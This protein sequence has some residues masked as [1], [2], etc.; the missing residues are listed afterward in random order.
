MN[1][2]AGVDVERILLFTYNGTRGERL[3]RDDSKMKRLPA[4]SAVLFSSFILRKHSPLIHKHRETPTSID[5]QIPYQDGIAFVYNW[6]CILETF[7][8]L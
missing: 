4:A 6:H 5:A 2:Q 7:K 3:S 1:N 8:Y